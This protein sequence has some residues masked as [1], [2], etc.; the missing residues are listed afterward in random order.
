MITKNYIILCAALIRFL[1]V[2]KRLEVNIPGLQFTFA[3]V[4]NTGCIINHS[5]RTSGRISKRL[6]MLQSF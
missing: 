2:P 5:W 3:K 4:T 6:I 1:E